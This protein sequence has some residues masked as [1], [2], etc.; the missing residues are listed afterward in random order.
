MSKTIIKELDEGLVAVDRHAI[1]DISE[2][3]MSLLYKA[4]VKFF[5][6]VSSE[7]LGNAIKYLSNGGKILCGNFD[8]LNELYITDCRQ[9]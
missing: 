8:A 7:H 1:A 6:R 3:A 5:S 9:C 2:E 4:A